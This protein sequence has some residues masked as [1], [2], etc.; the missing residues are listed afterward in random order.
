MPLCPLHTHTRMHSPAIDEG[1]FFHRSVFLGAP[2]RVCAH[3][4]PILHVKGDTACQGLSVKCVG[5]AWSDDKRVQ[6]VTMKSLWK[7]YIFFPSPC[8]GS[9]LAA[10]ASVSYLVLRGGQV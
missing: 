6:E 10:H 5:G 7:L 4:M 3:I 8:L 2:V 9:P 1:V